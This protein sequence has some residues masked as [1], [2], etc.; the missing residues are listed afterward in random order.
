[1]FAGPADARDEHALIYLN[2]EH[3]A[4][5][6]EADRV[7]AHEFMHLRW[8]S[9]GHKQIAFTAPNNFSSMGGLDRVAQHRS[10]MTRCVGAW[11]MDIPW[12]R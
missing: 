12:V 1:M 5:R 3:L 11:A 7:L 8:P 2:L 10:A 4:H 9:F 6:R